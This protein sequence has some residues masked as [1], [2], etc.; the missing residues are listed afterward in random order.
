MSDSV[1]WHDLECGSYRA[2]LPLW[3]ELAARVAPEAVLEIGAGTGR[4]ALDLAQRGHRVIALEREGE[5]ARELQRRAGRLPIEV[6]EA[7]ACSFELA[8]AVGLCIAPMQAVQLLEDRLGLFRSVAG[9][10][11]PG[12]TLAMA[13]LPEQLGAFELELDPDV[14]ERDG[15]LYASAPTALRTTATSVVLERRRRISG[16]REAAPALDVVQ[17]A[18]LTVA[19]LAREAAV[20]GFRELGTSSISATDAHVGSDVL[21]LTRGPQ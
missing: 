9:A 3:R 19:Q 12:G 14:L 10:L 18:R 2:D 1:V 11:R 5:L 8:R 17:L 21:L 7:D 6:I 20:A 16:E 15:V 4:V 13:I